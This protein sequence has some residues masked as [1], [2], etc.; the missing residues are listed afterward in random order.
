VIVVAFHQASL[1]PGGP[2]CKVGCPETLEQ[3]I[4]AIRGLR[5]GEEELV[6]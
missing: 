3:V 2:R 6:G 4:A 5:L 1:L